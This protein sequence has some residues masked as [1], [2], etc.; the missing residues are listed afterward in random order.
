[1]LGR[2]HLRLVDVLVLV[3]AA[4]WTVLG[5]GETSLDLLVDLRHHLGELHD[6]LVLIFALVALSVAVVDVLLL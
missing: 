3:L 4:L 6:Q 2:V 5:S 1:M